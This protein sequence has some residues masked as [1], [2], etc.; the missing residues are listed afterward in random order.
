M[1][2]NPI[3]PVVFCVLVAGAA[4]ESAAVTPPVVRSTE[5]NGNYT[6][7][8]YYP[9][10][11]WMNTNTVLLTAEA[12]VYCKD[13]DGF[14]A[15]VARH[16]T[17]NLWF[18]LNGNRLRFYRSGGTL[19]DSDGT[20]TARR[21]THV[22]VTYDGTTARFFI[23]GVNAG[24]KALANAGNNCTNSL[25]LGGQRDALNLGDVISGGYAFNGYLDEVR[26]WAVVR[27]QS[28]IAANRY[29]QVRAGSGLLAT[30]GTGG[31]LEDLRGTTGLTAGTP[32][33]DRWS[34]FGIL[35]AG[36]C[37]PRT[38]NPL[39]MDANIDML[40][41][42]RGAETLVLRSTTSSTTPDEVAYLMV[43]TNGSNHYL[44]V[45]LPALPQAA[46]PQI[47]KVEIR[48]DVN[49]TD[50]WPGLGDWQCQ[51]EQDSF[52]GGS[53][54][55]A[56][57]PL[58]PTPAWWSWG[59]GVASWQGMTAEA[60]EFHQNYEFRIHAQ[61]LNNFTN[62][63]GLMIRYLDFAGGGDQ[64]V[65]PH[66]AV[67][68][69]PATY[70]R[71]DWCGA[72][73]SDLSTVTLS[74]SVTNVSNQAGTA[75]L[76]VSL[77]SGDS[78]LSGFLLASTTTDSLGRF[79]FNNILAPN[80]RR[81]TITYAPP[82][83]IV[84]LD[85]AIDTSASSRVPVATNSPYSIRY[86]SC[87]SVC[88][89][90]KVNF[91]YRSLG[92][93][94]IHSVTPTNVPA[95]VV[96]RTTPFKTTAGSTITVAGTNFYSGVRLYFRGS[97]CALIPPSLCTSDFHEA[98]IVSQTIDGLSLVAE[99]PPALTGVA[100]TARS[101]Q[102]VMHNPSGGGSW[103]YGPSITVTPPLW[104]QLHGFEFINR[105]DGPSVE[106]FEA[107]YGDSIFNVFRFREPYYGI[108]ALV[109]LA[110]MD[111][112]K[113]SC[114]GM[115]GTSRLMAD[116]F[117]PRATFDLPGG[118]GVHGV[119]FAN[120]YLGT[121]ACEIG[122]EL[123]PPKPYRWTG[124]DLFQPYRPL[125]LW[126]RITSFAGAQTSAEALGAWLSQLQRP[127]AFG[128]RRGMAVAD[129]V[130][131][132]N[133]VRANPF[134]YTACVYTRD[135]GGGHCITP[136]GVID[137]MRLDTN[138][139]TPVVAANFSLIKVYDN[140]WPEQ[141]RYIEVNRTDN[142]FRYNS[143]G[144]LG[145][146]E[147]AGL[148]YVPASVYR[149]ARHAPDP[150]FLGRYGLEFLRILSVGASSA[151]M[152]DAH[153][154]RIGWDASGLTNDFE[155]ALP[156]LPP[157]LLLDAA[158]PLDTTML[159]LPAT[160]A[161]ASGG[162]YSAGGR[163]L[164]YGG[165]GWGDIAFG[166]N[167]P[168]TGA[169]NAVDGILIGLSQGLQGLG[170]RAGAP[171]TG[172]G[173]VVT[174]RDPLGQSR[175]F[176]LDADPSAMTPDLHLERDE[177]KSLTIRN[178]S[179]VP[180]SFRLNLSGTDNLVGTFDHAYESYS[181]PGMAT[182]KLLLPPNPAHGALTRQL[183]LNSDGTVDIVEAIPAN[184]QL[185]IAEEAGLVALRWRPA[186]FGETLETTTELK[187]GDWT[188]V[189]LPITTE[190]TD[191]V[192]RFAPG[193]SAEFFRL[194]LERTNCLSLSAFQP[195]VRPNPWEI[196][197]FR[198]E[199]LNAAGALQSQNSLVLRDNHVGLD[200]LHT[201]LVQPLADSGVVH[202]DVFQKSGFV[203]FEAVGPLSVVV[204]RQTLTGVGVAPERITLRSF[205]GRIHYVRVVSAQGQCLILNACSELAQSPP[206][207][208]V[209]NCVSFSQAAP[210]QFASP[211]YF[212]GLSITA[213][214][215]PVIVEPVFGE[216]GNWLKLKGEMD[217]LMGQGNEP[218]FRAR[219]LVKDEEGAVTV[220]AY[221]ANNVVVGT[222]GP[223]PAGSAPQELAVNGAGIVR[224]LIN[225][226]SDKAALQEVCWDRVVAP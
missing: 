21:W 218:C 186:S 23:D 206:N 131:V 125:N 82:S 154:G 155:G 39:T 59:Q 15:F 115:A 52:Q 50:A 192:L 22:A 35:P 147:G 69:L 219:L 136:Y 181:L 137:G 169:S 139:V 216:N 34:G 179:G 180:F 6:N 160:N 214:P 95:S 195:G 10:Q 19:A 24:I 140:N 16:Y 177:F 189:G 84:F 211:Y 51:L 40:N 85:P 168:N 102:I 174:S 74:G 61:H 104:P 110:W 145:I 199:A 156:Y 190:G 200:V 4:R 114:Y 47:P 89:Y 30:F 150:F 108:W 94:Q 202:L 103:I 106:E 183:D 153:G 60:F 141:E 86:A 172:F 36:L 215:D 56:N 99:V 105:D 77:Y 41:E 32:A 1:Y 127:V 101:F 75:G 221:D 73:D 217:I 158:N 111:G 119:L 112:C 72:A 2:R 11:S 142:T 163:A 71:T 121:P 65:G 116:G 46:L 96:V 182:V 97:G 144:S 135:F 152:T 28:A 187:P 130:D 209:S 70:A 62:S 143:G 44:Y 176:I 220:T 126:G 197:G 132:L 5:Y 57:P 68:N 157:G 76:T 20:L 191:R 81:L 58:F 166:F 92:P 29:N 93:V 213:K 17:T 146:Y 90:A 204:D 3:I 8:I 149:Q 43:S 223:P 83:S 80:E 7:I 161:P 175:V 25:S 18:G 9:V 26:L 193:Q 120:G 45:G 198:L 205:R 54:Y 49:V 67:T 124:F 14:Q 123:C 194:R 134:G 98:N 42:Y 226:N 210:G 66:G 151:S 91:R 170:L 117:L 55:R 167:A 122:G 129:P 78:E 88:T 48:G 63:M 118:D 133:R 109:Y 64:L 100:T 138:A 148:F 164:L 79:S 53:I 188:P 13:L 203:T 212:D 33:A 162:F 171:V 128:P 113:G 178:R 173:A 159:F 184:G 201:M 12:W 207:Q 107:C 185:R 222:A 165:M 87:P 225:S 31:H 208:L 224:L 38:G 196:N 37:I 27:S